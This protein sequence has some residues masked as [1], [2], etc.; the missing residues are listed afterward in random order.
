MCFGKSDDSAS[1]EMINMQKQEAAAA[2]AKEAARQQ[3]I[4][5]G[6][7]NI[8][9][10]FEGGKSTTTQT[11]NYDWSKFSPKTSGEQVS[12]LPAGYT[13]VWTGS[14]TVTPQGTPVKKTSTSPKYV[15]GHG[16]EQPSTG[17]QSNQYAGK[18]GTGH[19]TIN[20]FGEFAKAIN[21]NSG[22]GWLIRAPDGTYYKAGQNIATSQDVETGS[23]EGFGDKF[24]NKFKQGILDYYMPQVSDQYSDAKKEL[25][26]RLARAGTLR[27]SAAAEEVADLAKQNTLNEGKIRSQADTAAA[28]LR[29]R[30]ASEK[31]K[32]ESQLYAT[33]NPEV[34]ANQATAAIRNITAEKPDL[35]PLGEIFTL[36]SIGG[37]NYLKGAMNQSGINKVRQ[38]TGGGSS[39]IVQG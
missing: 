3:R 11:G 15:G 9:A 30:V 21:P 6:L 38:A 2:R 36:A 19:K 16:A 5:Q 4:N 17:Y 13:A 24:Y 33:E 8:K 27:S 14:D 10:M 28:D 35:T 31:S 7:A 32:A 18:G 29:N 37:A 1:R 23:Y 22:Q 25:T 12:G 20:S 39:R 26:Y 34:A